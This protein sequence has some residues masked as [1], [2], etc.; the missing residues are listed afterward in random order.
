[1]KKKTFDLK[2]YL[3]PK[4]KTLV[5]KQVKPDNTAY[6]GFKWPDSEKV[7][8]EK[9]VAEK[10]CG[11]GLHGFN[12][13]VGNASLADYSEGNI[14]KVVEVSNNGLIDLGGKVKF[15]SGYVIYSGDLKTAAQIIKTVFPNEAVIGCTATAGYRGTATAGDSGT[16][17]AGD[18]GTATAG[19]RGTATAGDRGT[20]TAGDSGTA[21][22]GDR[23]VL[24]ITYYDNKKSSYKRKIAL[25]GDNGIKPN[26][27][28]RLNDKAEFQEVKDI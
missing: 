4:G 8:C 13:G 18:S 3:L 14:W 9:W 5:L 21:T 20:A 26:V 7:T 16:A 12:K 10:E 6:G 2:K 11:N 28:Y 22:A 24:I 25:V 23:G 19:Y 27:K 1:M 17:T 15:K